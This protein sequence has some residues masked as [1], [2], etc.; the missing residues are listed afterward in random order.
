[1]G[2]GKR[3]G[4]V[5][6]PGEKRIFLYF[7]LFLGSVSLVWFLFYKPRADRLKWLKKEYKRLEKELE[8]FKDFSRKSSFYEFA[9]KLK[10]EEKF[11]DKK[12]FSGEEI[13]LA[14]ISKEARNSGLELLHIRPGT[15]KKVEY[16]QIS[17][18]KNFNLILQDIQ[19]KLRGSYV[20]LG[21]Y[22]E[23]LRRNER[24]LFLVKRVAIRKD[25]YPESLDITLWVSLYWLES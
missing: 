20:E 13:A 21:K 24:G 9:R 14:E 18:N 22:L 6:S 4:W 10:K 3:R 15:R 2:T 1:M 19:L 25:T 5:I 12:F 11:L 8:E 16:I 23:G 17:E 7:L